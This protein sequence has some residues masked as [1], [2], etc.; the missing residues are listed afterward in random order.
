M[1]MIFIIFFFLVGGLWET[2]ALIS[3]SGAVGEQVRITCSHANAFYNVKYFCRGNCDYEDVL[4]S[5]WET[6]GSNAKYSITDEGNTFIVTISHLKKEDTGTYWCG[7]ERA[8]LDTYNE[9]VLTVT[10]GNIQNPENDEKLVYIKAGLGVVA[11]AAV[12]LVL[13]LFL[14]HRKRHI[15]I[16]SSG[17]DHDATVSR[18]KEDALHSNTCPSSDSEKADDQ[19]ESIYQKQDTRKDYTGNIYSNIKGSSEAQIQSDALVYATVSLKTPAERS[20]ATPDT[21][22]VTYSTVTHTSTD[23]STLCSDVATQC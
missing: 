21:A 18:Q 14:R 2:E 9:V 5:S 4:I 23:E 8:G 10:E 6:K 22:L 19:I 13:V 12:M 7:I 15:I 11:F 20:P 16:A 1:E 17:E 3:V